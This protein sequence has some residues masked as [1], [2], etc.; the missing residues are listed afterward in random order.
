MRKTLNIIVSF[1]SLSFILLCISCYHHTLKDVCI[2][3]QEM[4]STLLFSKITN[5]NGKYSAY[6][7]VVF[8]PRGR[9]KECLDKINKGAIDK[10]ALK[11]F[12]FQI[13]DIPPDIYMNKSK[14]N[15][16]YQDNSDIKHFNDIEDANFEVKITPIAQDIKQINAHIIFS[17]WIGKYPYNVNTDVSMD[18]DSWIFLGGTNL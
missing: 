6:I 14:I 3:N 1:L 16:I 15:V 5:D 8:I 18:I 17:A 2:E 12:I 13:G 7:E 4:I 9:N 11:R 10:V